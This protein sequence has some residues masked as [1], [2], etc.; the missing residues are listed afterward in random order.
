LENNPTGSI[1]N[2]TAWQKVV[3]HYQSALLKLLGMLKRAKTI[4]EIGVAAD[5]PVIF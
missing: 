4:Y 3:R 2:Q 5:E 1:M